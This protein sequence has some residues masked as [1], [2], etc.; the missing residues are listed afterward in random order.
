MNNIKGFLILVLA[1]VILIGGAAALYNTLGG[2]VSPQT[3]FVM[4]MPAE[5]QTAMENTAD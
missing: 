5:N 4:Y 1:L 3:T 2:K